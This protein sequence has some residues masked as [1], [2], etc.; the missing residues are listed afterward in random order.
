MR[1]IVNVSEFLSPAVASLC[2]Y[3]ME[4]SAGRLVVPRGEVDVVEMPRLVLPH[5]LVVDLTREP[6]DIRYRLVGTRL[7]K[8][9]GLDFTG[10]RLSDFA[11]PN[12]LREVIAETYRSVVEFQMPAVGHYGYPAINGNLA[13]S[14][15]AVFPVSNDGIVTQCL[16]IEHLDVLSEYLPGDLAPLTLNSRPARPAL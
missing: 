13:M 3:W 7:A 9:Y 12:G 4:R 14:E 11:P 5:L 16:A 15:F 8:D 1:A 10:L 6:T 2:K